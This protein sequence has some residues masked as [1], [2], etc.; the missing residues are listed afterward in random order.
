M[1]PRLLVAEKMGHVYP[2]WPCPEGQKARNE[3]SQTI[4]Q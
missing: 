2:L 3:I 4:Q 1:T